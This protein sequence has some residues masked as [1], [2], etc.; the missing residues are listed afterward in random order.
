MNMTSEYRL[1]TYMWLE[2]IMVNVPSVAH[3]TSLGVPQQCL[4]QQN[5]SA[6]YTT[7]STYQM[8]PDA[9]QFILMNLSGIEILQFFFKVY[10]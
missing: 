3:P 1:M 6:W 5:C 7:I 10:S 4:V 2:P 9:A 8:V